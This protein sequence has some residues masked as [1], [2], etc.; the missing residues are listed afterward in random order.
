MSNTPA[1]STA[2]PLSL[3]QLSRDEMDRQNRI[4]RWRAPLKLPGSEAFSLQRLEQACAQPDCPESRMTLNLTLGAD[5]LTARLPRALVLDLLRSL[6]C[7]VG[8]DPM[9]PTDLAA[10]LLEAALLP[11]V[12]VFERGVG[13]AVGLHAVADASP[14]PEPRPDNA[15]SFMR[16]P[17]LLRGPGMSQTLWVEAP[18]RTMEI[19]LR[20]WGA[21]TRKMD[22]LPVP[23]MLQAGS[24]ILSAG[25][26]RSLRPGDAV[27]LQEMEAGQILDGLPSVMRLFV[28]DTFVVSLRRAQAGW[29][30]QTPLRQAWKAGQILSDNTTEG[31]A[32]A[33]PIVDLDELPVRLVFEAGRLELSLGEL[34]RLGAGSIL[35]IG[36]QPGQV[37]ILVNGQRIGDGE[38]VNIENRSGVRITALATNA[39]ERNP[40]GDSGA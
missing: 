1:S 14:H 23:L 17:F 8:F 38:L 28:A 12:E 11:L 24:T 39:D 35:E 22:Q 31:I 2:R 6:Q 18:A 3:P 10:L 33:E 30:L 15:A 27:L 9:P 37:R 36:T 20:N 4:A 40:H 29:R 34:R 7:G 19:L 5:P 26:I 21:G 13:L 16:V 25:L 32:V